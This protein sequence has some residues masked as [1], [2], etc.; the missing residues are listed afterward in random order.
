MRP[1][2]SQIKRHSSGSRSTIFDRPYLPL[3]VLEFLPVCA[4]LLGC[5]GGAGASIVTPPPPPPPPPPSITVTVTPSSSSVLLGNSQALSVQVTNTTDT[6]VTWSVN[7]VPGGTVA[8]GTITS[9]GTY[10]APADL[11]SPAIVQVAATSQAD[12]TKSATARLTITSDIALTLAPANASVELGATQAF[13]P[14]IASGGHPDTAVRWNLSGAACPSGCGSVDISGN[15]TAPGILPSTATATLTARSIADPSKQF[16]AP[17]N[18]TS[19]FTL[20]VTA[21]QS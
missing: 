18:I 12:T 6:S 9:G 15:Y 17:I 19:N 2:L 4:C 21:P 14:G 3:L 8:T 11:P 1:P 7:G 13:H 10:A 5:G 20:Q 16:F